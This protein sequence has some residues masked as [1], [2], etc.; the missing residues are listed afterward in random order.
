ML[1]PRQHRLH[2]SGA[3]EEEAS[4][5]RGGKP[6]SQEGAASKQR[7]RSQPSLNAHCPSP[8]CKNV[9]RLG[10]NRRAFKAKSEVGKV[11][12]CAYLEFCPDFSQAQYFLA[13]EAKLGKGF[14][15]LKKME[16][17]ILVG[18]FSVQL[19]DK[20]I[21]EGLDTEDATLRAFPLKK[22][23]RAN[24]AGQCAILRGER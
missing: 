20:L 21:E 22:N 17:H 6:E 12:L 19:A 1:M 8:R 16:G 13:L 24:S 15:L 10:R 4:R 7:P 5:L 14:Y 18:H 9:Q 2:Q 11:D 3:Q 23:S